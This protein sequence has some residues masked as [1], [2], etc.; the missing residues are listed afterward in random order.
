MV[1]R[2]C[3]HE[4]YKPHRILIACADAG[5]YVTGMKWSTWKR[6]IAVGHGTGHINDCTPNCAM[7]HFHK[8]AV[9]VRLSSAHFCHDVDVTQFR[10]LRLTWVHGPPTSSPGT[11][12]VPLACPVR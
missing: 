10:R 11:I 8:A 7:G 5:L 9:R 12:A 4:A 6:K 1:T 3:I 2:D